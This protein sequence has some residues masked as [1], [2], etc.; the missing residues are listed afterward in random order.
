MAAAGAA[1]RPYVLIIDGINRANISK[2]FGDLITLIE[3]DMR[4]DQ[5]NEI[6]V[7]LPYSKSAFGVPSNLHIIGTMDTADRSIALHQIEHAYLLGCRSGADIEDVMRHRIIPLL[8]S[9]SMT[10]GQR[11]RRCW[12][13]RRSRAFLGP[14]R[15]RFTTGTRRSLRRHAHPLASPHRRLRPPRVRPLMT[16]F[17]VLEH[18]VLKHGV[19]EGQIPPHLAARLAAAARAVGPAPNGPEGVFGD[20]RS[21]LRARGVVGALF[22]DG[23]RDPAEDR[24]ACAGGFGRGPWR[25]SPP[26]RAH[27]GG[28][29][30]PEAGYRAPL[31]FSTLE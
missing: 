29:T 2:V 21:E 13:C 16:T 22:A 1:R 3:P 4:L 20:R 26:A 19:A 25:H 18:G 5:T 30:G 10:I 11:S 24:R 15:D 31:G 14:G 9:I 12:R 17:S 8:L 7:T 28:R 6:R 23:P 27:A